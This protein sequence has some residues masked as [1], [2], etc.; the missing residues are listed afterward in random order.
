MF[1]FHEIF[2][3]F[4]DLENLIEVISGGDSRDEILVIRNSLSLRILS[5]E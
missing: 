4:V 2:I 1:V 3:V 5:R